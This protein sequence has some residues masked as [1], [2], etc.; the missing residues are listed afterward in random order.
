MQMLFFLKL[1]PHVRDS[2][3]IRIL[4]ICKLY[5]WPIQCWVARK[6]R[7]CK[8]NIFPNRKCSYAYLLC[9]TRY[10]SHKNIEILLELGKLFVKNNASF[11]IVTTIDRLES[12]QAKSFVEN[13]TDIK[14]F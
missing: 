2:H 3:F 13:I 14:S 5:P 8:K 1:K 9:L 11:K 6:M 12:L 4:K 7:E 10:Y